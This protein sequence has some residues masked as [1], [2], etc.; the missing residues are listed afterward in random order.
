MHVMSQE[1]VTAEQKERI[2]AEAIGWV[3]RLRDAAA[4][5]WAQFTSWLEADPRHGEAFDEAARADDDLAA[6]PARVREAPVETVFPYR[7]RRWA[8]LLGAS[9]AAALIMSLSYVSIRSSGE[10]QYAVETA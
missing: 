2:E 8:P 9:V 1:P 4:E 6:M 10:A 3:L 7:S 5:E